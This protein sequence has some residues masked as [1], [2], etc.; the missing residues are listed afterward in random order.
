MKNFVTLWRNKALQIN[1]RLL[2]LGLSDTTVRSMRASRVFTSPVSDKLLNNGA[3]SD[4]DLFSGRSF[5]PAYGELLYQFRPCQYSSKMDEGTAKQKFSSP[6]YAQLAQTAFSVREKVVNPDK[7]S[8]ITGATL[9]NS[10]EVL[11]SQH[12]QFGI[13]INYL[14]SADSS[15]TDTADKANA[16]ATA[17]A[18]ANIHKSVEVLNILSGLLSLKESINDPENAVSLKATWKKWLGS[19]DLDTFVN[20][21]SDTA[22]VT[23]GTVKSKDDV[24]KVAR[25]LDYMELVIPKMSKSDRD[26][27]LDDVMKMASAATETDASKSLSAIYTMLTDLELLRTIPN[28]VTLI[29]DLIL[30]TD[31][32]MSDDKY[33]DILKKTSERVNDIVCIRLFYAMQAWIALLQVSLKPVATSE[34]ITVLKTRSPELFTS[35]D[36]EGS[37]KFVMDL[38]VG[39]NVADL[40]SNLVYYPSFKVRGTVFPVIEMISPESTDARALVRA[41]SMLASFIPQMDS[42]SKLTS[43]WDMYRK[44]GTVVKTGK[45]S[46][47]AVGLAEDAF[48]ICFNQFGS[49]RGQSVQHIDGFSSMMTFDIGLNYKDSTAST[50]YMYNGRNTTYSPA[51]HA[52]GEIDYAEYCKMLDE[53][54]AKL[55]EKGVVAGFDMALEHHNFIPIRRRVRDNILFNLRVDRMYLDYGPASLVP[56]SVGTFIPIVDTTETVTEKKTPY[57]KYENERDRN[58]LLVS[59]IRNA[60]AGKM[61]DSRLPIYLNVNR[62]QVANGSSN[63][64][65]LKRFENGAEQGTLCCGALVQDDIFNAMITSVFLKPL[66]FLGDDIRAITQHHSFGDAFGG[67]SDAVHYTTLDVGPHQTVKGSANSDNGDLPATRIIGSRVYYDGSSGISSPD[68]VFVD[69]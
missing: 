32:K 8:N 66:S 14:A 69:A 15:K 17:E 63:V 54:A 37:I 40:L 52:Y 4:A 41:A 49:F 64:A 19:V 43:L 46:F 26:F 36:V 2:V 31:K 9:A 56:Y 38:P 7:M 65:I 51:T 44:G 62:S 33:V 5:S 53:S 6:S 42:L 23:N 25:G 3:L 16:Q 61:A 29:D 12:E 27:Y 1:Q 59:V 55:V 57:G 22:Y 35:F 18:I 47:S 21:N 45:I 39:K 67:D 10:I 58:A 20:R 60:K 30:L 24:S 13:L 68:D 50:K 34:I 11:M 48:P 28:L